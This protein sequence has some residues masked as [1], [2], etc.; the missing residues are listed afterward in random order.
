[1]AEHTNIE[2]ADATVQARFWALVRRGAVDACWPWTGGFQGTGYGVFRIG[3]RQTTAHRVAYCITH[4]HEPEGLQVDHLCRNRACC[5]PTH[6]EAV[7]QAENVRRGLKGRMVTSCTNGHVYT[8]ENT[9]HH[10][11]TGRRF[12]RE[13]RRARDRER[14]DA[15][16]WRRRREAKKGDPN[17]R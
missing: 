10:A 13:C 15:E 6:L 17:E 11:G 4:G 7:T 14:H 9:G 16:F 5:N 12:C 3:N 1:M 2:W 8:P